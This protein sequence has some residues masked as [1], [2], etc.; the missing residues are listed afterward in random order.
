MTMIE[1]KEDVCLLDSVTTYSI[2]KEK[3]YFSSMTL[4]K[5]NVYTIFGHVE[6][7]DGSENTTIMLPNGTTLHI[8]DA[9]LSTKIKKKST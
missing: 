3:N 5:V 9:L 8:E 1:K 6:M 4:C 7:I 2:L